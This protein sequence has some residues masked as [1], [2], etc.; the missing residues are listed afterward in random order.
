MQAPHRLSFWEKNV[1]GEMSGL[2]PAEHILSVRWV[3]KVNQVCIVYL[4][5]H[6]MSTA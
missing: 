4:H 1:Q 6:H 3:M 2:H 5:C